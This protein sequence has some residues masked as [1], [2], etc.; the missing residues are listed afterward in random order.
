MG[1]FGKT[2]EVL[3]RYGKFWEVGKIWED[4]GRHGKIW[5]VLGSWK[6]I[7]TD[8]QNYKGYQKSVY[9]IIKNQIKVT[10]ITVNQIVGQSKLLGYLNTKSLKVFRL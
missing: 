7:F 3:G 8:Y 4:L 9:Q 10:K 5:E 1:S 6:M 2:R